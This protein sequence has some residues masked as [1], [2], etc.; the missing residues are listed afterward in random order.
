M[1]NWGSIYNYFSDIHPKSE[2][3]FRMQ[4]G[5]SQMPF[6]GGAYGNW[7]TQRSVNERN[8]QYRTNVGLEWGD[9][10]RPWIASSV[11]G[12]PVAGLSSLTPQVSENLKELYGTDSPD[13]D[14][15]IHR[16]LAEK[17][18]RAQFRR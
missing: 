13:P 12:N 4:Q 5:L 10:K 8:N 16:R 9:I 1:P 18:Y 3:Q 17:Y 15:E 6:I 14:D 2:F 11:Q 7:M